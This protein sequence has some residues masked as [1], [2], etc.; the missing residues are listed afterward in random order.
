MV[1]LLHTSPEQLEV[2]FGSCTCEWQVKGRKKEEPGRPRGYRRQ[3]I[4]KH[5]CLSSGVTVKVSVKGP[6]RQD[7]VVHSGTG[8][9]VDIWDWLCG[10][11]CGPLPSYGSKFFSF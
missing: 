9:E 3:P 7:S 6:G 1:A 2:G 10:V 8:R 4:C 11:K 5:V